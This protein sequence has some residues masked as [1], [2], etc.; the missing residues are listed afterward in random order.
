MALENDPGH[1]GAHHERAR[2]L[3]AAPQRL[4]VLVGHA[5]QGQQL[6]PLLE[7]RLG[8]HRLGPRHDET[9]LGDDA[10]LEELL[11]PPQL[12]LGE[13]RVGN[14]VQ[15]GALRLDQLGRLELGKRRALLDLLIR[16]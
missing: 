9:A 1:G 14:G 5:R 15:K 3:T 4:D 12:F 7:R 2:K 13:I 8:L 10:L 6:P 11:V 16:G